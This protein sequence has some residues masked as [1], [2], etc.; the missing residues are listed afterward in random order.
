MQSWTFGSPFKMTRSRVVSGA[1]LCIPDAKIQ[2]CVCIAASTIPQCS[3]NGAIAFCNREKKPPETGGFGSLWS[4]L[5][6]CLLAGRVQGAGIMDFRDLVI[7]EPKNLTQ[8]LVGML[9]EQG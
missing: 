1:K 4:F 3:M 7:A 6:G 8:H 5:L 9:A 2:P